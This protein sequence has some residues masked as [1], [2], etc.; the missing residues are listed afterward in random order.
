[1]CILPHPCIFSASPVQLVVSVYELRLQGLVLLSLLLCAPAQ[2]AEMLR[3][4]FTD[5]PPGHGKIY[6]SNSAA[7]VRELRVLAGNTVKLQSQQGERYQAQAGGWYWT[8]VQ[9]V[10]AQANAVSITPQLQGANVSLEIAIYRQH[11]D[12]SS[13]YSTTVT[14]ALGEWLQLLGPEHAAAP[15]TRV[16]SA[17]SSADSAQFHPLGLFVKVDSVLPAN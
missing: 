6:S 5:R 16:Y 7:P 2:A 4:S 1:M 13:S 9:Q 14:G 8:Q 11:N 3:I 10:P 15:G 17:G 12:R